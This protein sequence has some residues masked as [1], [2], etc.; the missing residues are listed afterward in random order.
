MKLTN[1]FDLPDV[2]V[3]AL[4]QNTYDKGESTRSV[5]QLIDS[6]RIGILQQEH[7]DEIEQDVV[8]F[9]WARF[10]TGMH[11]MFEDATKG[12]QY[13][14]EERIFHDHMGWN[15]SGAIDLLERTPDGLVIRDYKVTSK[16]SVIF[17]KDEWHNQMNAYGWLL[18]HAK[19]TSVCRLEIVAIIRDWQRREAEKD[20]NYPQSPIHIIDIPIWSDQEQDDYIDG[21]IELHQSAAFQRL[22][23]Q[24]LPLCSDEERWRKPTKWAIKKGKNIR[25][26]RVLNTEEEADDFL[27]TKDSAHHIEKRP[28]ECTRCVQNWCRVNEWCQ[29]YQLDL[30][31][32]PREESND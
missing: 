23:R 24:E 15:I 19:N 17:G 22:T 18:R 10:G 13:T 25:A 30:L 26:V 28:G 6:P 2:V 8:D 5:T 4:T 3:E 9:L 31:E 14:T 27:A 16:W 21:R 32:L 20:R 29:Q 1:Q 11:E 7:D 12:D